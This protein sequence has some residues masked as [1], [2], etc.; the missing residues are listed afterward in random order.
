MSFTSLNLHPNEFEER[1]WEI[2]LFRKIGNRNRNRNGM[3][4]LMK[5]NIC[6]AKQMGDLI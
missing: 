5:I 6:T 2:K 1:N 4:P 3:N